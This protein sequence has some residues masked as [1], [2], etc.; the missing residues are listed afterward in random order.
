M[1]HY[2]VTPTKN[3]PLL[4]PLRAL[5]VIGEPLADLVQPNLRVVVNLGYGDPAYG[6]STSPPNVPTLFGLFPE[7]NPLAVADALA[8]GT[9]QGIGDFAYAITHLD[10][11]P[12]P[13]L[14]PLPPLP[15]LPP[16][17]GGVAPAAPPGFVI[18]GVIDNLQAASSNAANTLSRF[19][20]TSYS[21]MLPTADLL[22]ALFTTA[23]SYDINLFLE[24][25]RQAAHGDPM[26]L[27]N[28]VGYPLAADTA[29]LTVAVALQLLIV[30]NAAQA[31]AGI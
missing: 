13:S 4:E 12:L 31:I 3:L 7:V 10:L 22:N 25:V 18:D 15:T 27:I 17:T 19:A 26:G 1:T 29:L 2:Y 9:H 14:P 8:A 21:T 11:P 6:Y 30:I 24:G 23:P 20:E 28:A 5:P 16:V